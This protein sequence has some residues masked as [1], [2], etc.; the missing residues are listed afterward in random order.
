M[1]R[2]SARLLNHRS[3]SQLKEVLFL[4][5]KLPIARSARK[6][7]KG[8]GGKLGQP[9]ADS[10]GGCS[11]SIV[12]AGLVENMGEM[13]GDCSFTQN[14]FVGDLAVAFACDDEAQYLNLAFGK[15]RRQ[16]TSPAGR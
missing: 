11:R 12:G 14:Q 16:Q 7:R 13:I 9:L 1:C 15:S 4:W 2:T 6:W 3:H 8:G 5:S 10:K